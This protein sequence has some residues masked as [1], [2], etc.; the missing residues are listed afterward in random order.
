M[1]PYELIIEVRQGGRNVT[2]IVPAPILAADFD[3]EFSHVA[4]FL[5]GCIKADVLNQERHPSETTYIHPAGR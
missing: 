3:K 1:Q 5:S 4:K 2:R